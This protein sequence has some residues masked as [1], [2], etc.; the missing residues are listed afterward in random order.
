[1]NKWNNMAAKITG[2]IR[3]EVMGKSLVEVYIT[4]E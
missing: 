3:D 2:F 1:V 4:E